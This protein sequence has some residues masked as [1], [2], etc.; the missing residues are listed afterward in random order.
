LLHFRKAAWTFSDQNPP[1]SIPVR[2]GLER[3]IGV[4]GRTRLGRSP[5]HPDRPAHRPNPG[6]GA[7]DPGR[8]AVPQWLPAVPYVIGMLPFAALTLASP[9]SSARAQPPGVGS[10]PW[11]GPAAGRS[12]SVRPGVESGHPSGD[13]RGPQRAAETGARP[14]LPRTC[15]A[16]RSCW[17]TTTSGP[18]WSEAG[19]TPTRSSSTSSTSILR[20]GP[21]TRTGGV[22]STTSCSRSTPRRR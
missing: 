8:P 6:H 21:S 16:V 9:T 13:D 2:I 3:L 15:R 5:P 19:S 4:R 20:C 7:G 22:T 18:I 11:P 1:P 14:R 10:R 17:P 12:S